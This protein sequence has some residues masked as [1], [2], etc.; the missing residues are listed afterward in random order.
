MKRIIQHAQTHVREVVRYH[1]LEIV[2]TRV[3]VA[4]AHAQITARQDVRPHVQ[5]HVKDVH[6]V[7]VDVLVAQEVAMIRV[8]ED[9]PVIVHQVVKGLVRDHAMTHAP[10]LVPEH[11]KIRVPE[12]V[13]I[14]A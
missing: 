1:V 12:A 8:Q 2:I 4:A 9:A 3:Q 14:H 11:V 7:L 13:V 10:V 6:H 5:V